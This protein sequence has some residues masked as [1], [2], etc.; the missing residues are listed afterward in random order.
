MEDGVN[1]ARSNDAWRIFART[2]FVEDRPDGAEGGGAG[3]LRMM[4]TG[5]RI[6]A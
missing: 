5:K 3:T 1:A 4:G 6:V 2:F